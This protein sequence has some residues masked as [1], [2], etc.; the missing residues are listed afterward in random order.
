LEL[1]FF[2]SYLQ[3]LELIQKA[4]DEYDWN[5]N[6]NEV[7]RVWE[8]GCII[9]SQMIST[10]QSY[11][12]LNTSSQLDFIKKH[13]EHIPKVKHLI[14]QTKVPMATNNAS[15]DYILT[16]IAK[17]LPTNLIQ[18]QRDYFGEHT[19]I[20]TDTGETVTGGWN[21]TNG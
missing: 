1:S 18:A 17:H 9:R 16:L 20:R 5:V 4:S 7:L 6:L 13:A 2:A 19:F 21:K 14:A 15:I 8:G 10:L 12:K 3:G 11:I